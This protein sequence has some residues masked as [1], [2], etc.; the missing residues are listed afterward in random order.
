[1]LDN[2]MFYQ[3]NDEFREYVDKYR[4]KH[5]KS[6]KDALQDN[7]IQMAADYYRMKEEGKL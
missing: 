5:D 3:T 4:K 1:M 2:R 7:L 6:V